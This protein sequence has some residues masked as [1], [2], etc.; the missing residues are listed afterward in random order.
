MVYVVVNENLSIL[1]IPLGCYC[2]D[3]NGTCPYWS[4]KLDKPEQES[5]YCY[6]LERGDWQIRDRMGLLWDMVKECGIND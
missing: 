1:S 4:N 6:Y 3:D 5:G 2:Y